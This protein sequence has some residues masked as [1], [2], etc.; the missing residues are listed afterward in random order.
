MVSH[1]RFLEKDFLN[2]VVTKLNSNNQV[3]IDGRRIFDK[4]ELPTSI[5][6]YYA[7]GHSNFTYEKP[8][9]SH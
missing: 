3:L 6:K 4:N 2:Q 5:K 9:I 7:V 1:A 8:K